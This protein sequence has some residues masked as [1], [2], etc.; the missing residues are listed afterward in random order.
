MKKVLFAS[1][2]L[3]MTAGVAAADVTISGSAQ[4]GVKSVGGTTSVVNDIDIDVTGSASTDGGVTLSASIDLDADRV[5]NAA[6]TSNA[7]DDP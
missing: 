3:V 6:S 2:A 5:N 7:I 1:T 4:M